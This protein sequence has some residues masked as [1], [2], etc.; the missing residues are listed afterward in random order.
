MRITQNTVKRAARTFLQAVLAYIAVHLAVV[1]FTSGKETL[2]SAL[3]GLAV[4][5]VASGIAAAMNLERKET[6]NDDNGCLG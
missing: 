2:K 6:E 3:I 5:A 4:S 1:D